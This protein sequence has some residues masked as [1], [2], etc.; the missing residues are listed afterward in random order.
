[1]WLNQMFGGHF[2]IG[3]SLGII[4]GVLAVSIGASLAFP[5][6]AKH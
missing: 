5:A 2:P 3:L 4:L 1:L 6:K